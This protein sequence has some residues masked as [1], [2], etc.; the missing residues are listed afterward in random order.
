MPEERLIKKYPNRRLYD[1][2]ESSYITL[3]EVRQ[4]VLKET[5]FKVVEQKTGEDITRSI[6]LQ[7]ILE[8]ESEGRPMF[9]SDI[10]ANF[11]RNY[12]A[13]SQEEFSR[14]L[15]QSLGFFA[16]QQAKLTEQMGKAFEGTPMEFWMK[17]G[18]TQMKTWQ[19]MQKNIFEKSKDK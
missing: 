5:P 4:M 10:L 9:S 15:E 18:E 16:E 12:G 17:L 14:Y 11:I 6:L 2:E 8:Q 7:I 1:T 13:E 3:E 19:E